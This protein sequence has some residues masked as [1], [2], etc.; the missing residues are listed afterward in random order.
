MTPGCAAT[1]PGHRRADRADKATAKTP[2]AALDRSSVSATGVG[3]TVKVKLTAKARKALRKVRSVRFKVAVTR[4]AP[5]GAIGTAEPH[6]D[7]QPLRK[8]STARCLLASSTVSPAP[9]S[10]SVIAPVG[11]S[12][13]GFAVPAGQLGADQAEQRRAGH[14]ASGSPS[15]PP[16]RPTAGG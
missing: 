3:A 7:D 1:L 5:T 14:V 2:E 8:R 13:V 4:P 12:T 15:A 16:T 10:G 6:R 9:P 11:L